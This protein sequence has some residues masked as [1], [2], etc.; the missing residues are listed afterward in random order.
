MHIHFLV[1]ESTLTQFSETFVK[2][3]QQQDVEAILMLSAEEGVFSVEELDPILKK[4]NKPVFGG[5]F[6]QIIYE[7]NNYTQGTLLIGL[8]EKPLMNVV[9]NLSCAE[10]DF[11]KYFEDCPKDTDHK[12]AFIV[13]DAFSTRVSDF[14]ESFF[15]FYGLEFNILGGGAGSLSLEQKPCLYSNEGVLKDAAILAI[16]NVQ[17]GI[18]VRH[19]WKDLSGPYKAAKTE[20]NRLYTLDTEPAFMLYKRV[21]E[22]DSK[23]RI[24]HHNFFDIAK[25]YPFGISRL[26]AEKIVRDPYLVNPD[27]SMNF[28]GE[29]PQ[30]VYLHILKGQPEALIQSAGEAFEEANRSMKAVEKEK[31]VVFIDCISRVLFLQDDFKQELNAIAQSNYPLIGALTLGEI[32]NNQKEFLEFYNKTAVVSIIEGL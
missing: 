8:E 14:I 24:T 13:I 3:E 10:G 17:S 31:T 20:K 12:T 21:V 11:E 19:G 27:E 1:G 26:G 7:K 9:K 4:A 32:A 6:P 5:M 30:G 15:N 16:F 25:A 18:G 2:L 22:Q 23:Q 28:F 29:I